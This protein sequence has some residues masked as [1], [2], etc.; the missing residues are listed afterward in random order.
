M[1]V[2]NVK[3]WST[4]AALV[5]AG[6]GCASVALV[7]SAVCDAETAGAHRSGLL[8]RLE[9]AHRDCRAGSPPPRDELNELEQLFPRVR[10][11]VSESGGSYRLAFACLPDPAPR[12][13]EQE[14]DDVQ[15][16]VQV[17]GGSVAAVGR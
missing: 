11:V 14:A 10:L 8:A 15:D 9:Q 16:E 13:Q 1:N 4:L 12:G 5:A 7:Q 6:F 3:R 2:A 17:G